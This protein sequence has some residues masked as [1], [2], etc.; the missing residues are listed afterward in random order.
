[1]A[2]DACAKRVKASVAVWPSARASQMV[3]KCRKAHG[4]VRKGKAGTSLRRW[5]REKWTDVRTGRPCGSNVRTEYCRPTER[6][7]KKKTPTMKPS[8]RKTAANY[9]RKAAG[10]RAKRV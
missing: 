6:V 1:M 5:G 2:L 8:A 10:K 7:S 4:H 9:H 3:A